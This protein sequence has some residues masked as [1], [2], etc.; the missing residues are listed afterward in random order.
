MPKKPTIKH[1]RFRAETIVDVINLRRALHEFERTTK[2]LNLFRLS[3]SLDSSFK[4]AILMPYSV[5]DI[6]VLLSSP[7]S[8][9]DIQI[10]MKT[11]VDSHVMAETLTEF[12]NYTGERTYNAESADLEVIRNIWTTLAVTDDF[13]F[14]EITLT[15]QNLENAA[16]PY[17]NSLIELQKILSE[18][19]GE[20]SLSPKI[21]SIEAGSIT[22]SFEGLGDA[23]TA[24]G[25][26]FRLR[27]K[28][29]ETE[30]LQNQVKFEEIRT[31]KAKIELG[32]KQ[33]GLDLLKNNIL[34]ETD[35]QILNVEKQARLQNTHIE[36]M[37]NLEDLRQKR[38]END[39]KQLKLLKGYVEV[40]Q[41]FLEPYLPEDTPL[42]KRIE[43][44][45][46]VIKPLQNI[47]TSPLKLQQGRPDTLPGL[48]LSPNNE[49][50]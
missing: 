18:I 4:F 32:E 41:D 27:K 19:K 43:Y 22:F 31:E 1:Y 45:A 48:P 8:L 16:L 25:E 20:K 17:V 30:I 49:D 5:P 3:N 21:R 24:V 36:Y 44:I 7:Y 37:K 38:L 42:D 35:P 26:F 39:E 13:Y 15:I 6:E 9:Q 10:V 23:I 50:D 14:R 2:R 29:A 33:L 46:K 34:I 47:E 40:A 28:R 11:V 12:D